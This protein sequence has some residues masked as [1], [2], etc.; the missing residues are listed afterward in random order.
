[1]TKDSGFV[2]RRDGFLHVCVTRPVGGQ[3]FHVA[4]E[5]IERWEE[6][7]G[8]DGPTPSI[9]MLRFIFLYRW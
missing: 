4:T 6:G 9:P 5:D 8:A 3:A 2:T 1:M 7:A